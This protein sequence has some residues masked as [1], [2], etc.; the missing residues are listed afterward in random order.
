MTAAEKREAIRSASSNAGRRLR[1][2][3]LGT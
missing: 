2:A 1:I 3:I